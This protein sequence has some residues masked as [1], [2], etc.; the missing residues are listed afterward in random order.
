MCWREDS[1]DGGGDKDRHGLCLWDVER[2]MNLPGSRLGLDGPSYGGFA[3]C[4]WPETSLCFLVPPPPNTPSG[5]EKILSTKGIVLVIELSHFFII[6]FITPF[7]V[8]G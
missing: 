5:I 1:L 8:E 4:G 7:A 3:T 6:H 2:A